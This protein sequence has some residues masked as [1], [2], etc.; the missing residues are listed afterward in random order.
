[1]EGVSN[2]LRIENGDRVVS[3][4]LGALRSDEFQIE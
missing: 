2:A 3:A 1:M 4:G